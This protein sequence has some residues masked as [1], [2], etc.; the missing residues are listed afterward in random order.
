M[1]LQPEAYI[2]FEVYDAE[3]GN[4]VGVGNVTPP[5]IEFLTQTLT[6]AGIGGSIEAVIIGMTN[7]MTTT[8]S[9][10]SVTD[11]AT[12]LASPKKHT[13][14]V[15]VAEQYWDTIEVEKQVH[16]DRFVMVVVPKSTSIGQISPATTASV[17]GEYTVYRFE[18]YNDSEELFCIDPFNYVCRV[19][20]VDY[21]A[22][23]RTA[24]GKN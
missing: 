14:D 24:L 22:E 16:A 2:D 5:N 12:K 21:S 10:R 23:I 19:G 13:L 3:H 4:L 9:F 20:G 1:A 7:A 8:L 11:A 17:S 15:R 18:A 6:G